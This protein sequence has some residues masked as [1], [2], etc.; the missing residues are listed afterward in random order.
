[1][2]KKYTDLIIGR[3]NRFYER[4]EKTYLGDS[5]PFIAEYCWSKDPVAFAE[6]N[7][8]KYK[9]IKEGD[10]WG[11]KWES[12]W[13]HL[14]GE[15]PAGWEGE[16]VVAHLDF[17]GEGL[18]FDRNGKALQG[19]TNGSI[20]DHNFK[21]IWVPLFDKCIGSE[22]V[23]L[24]V[25]AAAN[26]LFGVYTDVDPAE[27][28]NN[29]YGNFAA[30]VEVMKLRIFHEDLWQFWLDFRVMAILCIVYQIIF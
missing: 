8:L 12:A 26:S 3:I 15:V 17:S 19:I 6:K 28:D 4:L 24:W 10:G 20:F 14:K 22:P 1:M 2:N 18:V 11:E 9:S 25:E 27:D 5:V 30:K 21:R 16:K 29:R 13:F 23:E 7:N